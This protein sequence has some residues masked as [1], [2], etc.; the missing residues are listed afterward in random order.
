[1][2]PA[3][4]R[5]G[6]V[7]LAFAAVA[8]LL[9]RTPAL[10]DTTYTPI[11]AVSTT[12]ND[13]NDVG[14]IVPILVTHPDGELKY[15]AAP[16]FVQNSIVGARATMNV[17]RYEPGGREVRFI[18][19]Y[20][21]KIERQ[22]IF[23]YTDPAFGHGRYALSYG[24]NFFKNATARFFGISQQTT[25][26]DETNYTA[27]EVNA[28]WKFGVYL[29]EV[30]QLAVSQRYREVRVQ[31][32]AT[33]LPFTSERFPTVD[34]VNGASVLGHRVTFHYD[35]R[36]HLVTPTTGNQVMA[37]YEAVQNLRNG[38]HPLYQRFGIDVKTML[39]SQSKRNIVVARATLQG[40]AGNQVPFYELSS[41]GGQNSLRG[42]GVDRFIDNYLISFSIESRLHIFRANLM[43]TWAEFEVAPFVDMGK[44]FNTL[45][46]DQFTDYEITPG[47]GFRALVRPNVVGRIDYGLSKEGGAVFAGLDFPF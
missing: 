38:D 3:R 40:V 33:S 10:A 2:R 45:R 6:L 18:A 43:N 44:V 29:N 24:A 21:E 39:P 5:S 8:L 1:M 16:M 17:F 4:I 13:G 27:R 22:L 41:L 30:T 47:L 7:S 19:S 12:R 28:N 32:G 20:T 36:D 34:G 9:G 42:Y 23:S 26:N 46:K 25:L 37:Y 35:T 14:M 11:P 31:R 15:I